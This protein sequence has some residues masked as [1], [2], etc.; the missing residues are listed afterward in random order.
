MMIMHLYNISPFI[1]YLS[2]YTISLHLY[3]ISPFIQ[4]LSIYTISLQNLNIC[5]EFY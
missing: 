4:Y 5:Q 3:N 1:Q 2:I